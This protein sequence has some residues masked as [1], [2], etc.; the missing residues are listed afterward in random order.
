[1]GLVSARVDTCDTGRWEKIHR[2]NEGTEETKEKKK[3]AGMRPMQ[4]TKGDDH[5]DSTTQ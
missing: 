4:D 2:Q 1:M 5:R 3:K